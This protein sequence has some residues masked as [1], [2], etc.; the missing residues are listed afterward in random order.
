M[1]NISSLIHSDG[2]RNLNMESQN[3]FGGSHCVLCSQRLWNRLIST[4][5]KKHSY[6]YIH[7]PCC[8][9]SGRSMYTSS[10][11]NMI[12]ITWTMTNRCISDTVY[13]LLAFG[14]YTLRAC[15]PHGNLSQ[16]VVYHWHTP[17]GHGL[18]ITYREWTTL[19]SVVWRMNRNVD[20][21]TGTYHMQ[22]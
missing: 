17:P 5:S 3:G 10:K 19:P 15:V 22:M 16:Q 20:V 18:Y 11:F 9:G 8:Y 14:E 6:A 13:H 12:Y 4:Q 2:S 7:T 1:L 21:S